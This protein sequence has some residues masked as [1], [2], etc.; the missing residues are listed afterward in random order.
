MDFSNLNIEYKHKKKLYSLGIKTVN[1]LLS[2]LEIPLHMYMRTSE[3][4]LIEKFKEK[5]RFIGAFEDELRY[6]LVAHKKHF[7]RVTFVELSRFKVEPISFFED[8]DLEET[9]DEEIETE[10][11]E[12]YADYIKVDCGEFPIETLLIGCLPKIVSWNTKL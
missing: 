11:S 10:D 3:S 4:K 9:S 2:K 1:Q 6:F 12:D 7:T 5:Y 8:E